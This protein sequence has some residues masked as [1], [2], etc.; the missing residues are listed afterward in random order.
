MRR[1]L[2]EAGPDWRDVIDR[3]ARAIETEDLAANRHMGALGAGLI[4]PGS[5]VLTHCNT[6]S[7]AT[8]GFGTALGVVRAGVS[9][10]RIERVFAD[11]TPSSST[12]Q[13]TS[14]L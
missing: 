4:T 3:E 6:G 8:A 14:R 2:G 11:D 7:L 1:V 13:R 5:G 12:S 10:G 9:S